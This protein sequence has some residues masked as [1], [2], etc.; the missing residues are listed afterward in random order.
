M[1]LQVKKVH[2]Q[3]SS[4]DILILRY[5]FGPSLNVICLHFIAHEDNQKNLNHKSESLMQYNSRNVV[6]AE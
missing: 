5:G 1:G 4:F 2:H 6:S 3:I